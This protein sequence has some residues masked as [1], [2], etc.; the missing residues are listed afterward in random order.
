MAV[1]RRKTAKDVF[2]KKEN[3]SVQTAHTNFAG[4]IKQASEEQC[5]ERRLKI[6]E[7][8]KPMF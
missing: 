8:K 4:V 7:R 1:E 6:C 3:T 2:S 5:M